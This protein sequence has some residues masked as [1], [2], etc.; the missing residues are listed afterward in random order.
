MLVFNVQLKLADR[1]TQFR[2]S[3]LKEG[4]VTFSNP[5]HDYPQRITYRRESNGTL[6]ARIEGTIG[7]KKK[8]DDFKYKRA[9]CGG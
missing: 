8:Q 1:S 4:A 3:E 2:L 6:F 9:R 7:G 5:E